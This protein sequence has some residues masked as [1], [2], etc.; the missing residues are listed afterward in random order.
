MYKL[1]SH[2]SWIQ[3]LRFE[4]TLY[5]IVHNLSIFF[6]VNNNYNSKH[7]VQWLSRI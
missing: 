6:H 2:F 7:L 1:I 3:L 4:N 5:P